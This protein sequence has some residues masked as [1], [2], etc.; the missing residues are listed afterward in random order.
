MAPVTA[1]RWCGPQ[2]S[3]RAWAKS[4]C[5]CKTISTSKNS[6]RNTSTCCRVLLPSQEIPQRTRSPF[7]GKAG[8]LRHGS[9]LYGALVVRIAGVER[10]RFFEGSQRRG[11]VALLQTNLANLKKR[12]RFF[13]IDL[14]R[15]GKRVQRFVQLALLFGNDSLDV[16]KIGLIRLQRQSLR[17]RRPRSGSVSLREK[18]FCLLRVG[19]GVLRIFLQRPVQQFGGFR[20]LILAR[21]FVGLLDEVLRLHFV[22][23]RLVLGLLSRGEFVADGIGL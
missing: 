1:I 20:E 16:K 18:D 7:L 10:R 17:N 19:E 21:Q 13:R 4:R 8:L 6:T 15:F 14:C 22:F 2:D 9:G 11:P 23:L 3:S 12:V 5:K